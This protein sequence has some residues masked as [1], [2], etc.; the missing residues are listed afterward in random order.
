MATQKLYKY[1]LLI[2]LS[3]FVVFCT[4]KVDNSPY[5]FGSELQTLSEDLESQAYKDVVKTMI[6]QDLKEEWKR[7]ATPDNYLAFSEKYGGIGNIV[8][9]SILNTAYLQREKI[10]KDFM[11]F[12]EEAFHKIN[13]K[14]SY[15]STE[16]EQLLLAEKNR[17]EAMETLEGIKIKPV[18][19]ISGA[20]KQWPC[21]RGPSGQG[22]ANTK[23]IPL[24]WS[25]TENIVWKVKLSGKGNSS[26]V[27]WDNR[28]FITSATEDGKTR[29]LFCYNRSN[30][31]L[32]WKNKAPVPEKVEKLYWKNSYASSTPVTDGERVIT[33]LGNSGIVC[34]NMDGELQWSQNLGNFTTMHGPGTNPILYKDK[35]IL[36]QDQ[37]NA[38]SVFIA[39]NKQTG[40]IIWTQKRESVM[41]W[42]SPIIVRIEDHD[43]L[44][45]NG[46]YNVKG[47]NPDTGAEIWTLNGS[48]KEAVPIIVSGGGLFFSASGRNGAI[49]AIRPGGKGN[50]TDTHL[51]WKN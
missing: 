34:F 18:M 12:M 32:L 38:E 27:I 33:F 17:T 23:K 6:Y 44:V 8:A 26:P 25:P 4:T 21:F 35:V 50:I 7:V 29:E 48:T 43:E 47:Y 40:E 14:P 5:P 2:V 41:G 31:E 10:A 1:L 46:S 37:N 36:I 15:T 9:D 11:I 3:G 19:P 51:F 30:G 42:S 49:M 20:E 45:Y 39:L 13:K 28:I 16:V 24:N 22:I